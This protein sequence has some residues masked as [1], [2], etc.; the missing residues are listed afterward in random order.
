MLLGGVTKF[1]ERVSPLRPAFSPRE[2]D[3]RKRSRARERD[4][5]VLGSA[6]LVARARERERERV[7]GSESERKTERE[8]ERHIAC[9]GRKRKRCGVKK[10]TERPDPLSPRA[11]VRFVIASFSRE[12]RETGGRNGGS[13]KSR[14]T[15]ERSRRKQKKRKKKKETSESGARLRSLSTISWSALLER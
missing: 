2:C 9:G 11:R 5:N 3:E 7:E 13:E 1:H 14:S 4:G 15:Q 10:N 8:R 12:R 6:L